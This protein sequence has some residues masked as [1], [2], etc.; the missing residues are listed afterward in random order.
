VLSTCSSPRRAPIVHNH[1][2]PRL[3]S[4]QHFAKGSV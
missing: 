1:V 4:G 3:L 2:K